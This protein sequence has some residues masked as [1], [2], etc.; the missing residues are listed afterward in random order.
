MSKK[1]ELTVKTIDV[2]GKLAEINFSDLVEALD[3]NGEL[4][5]DFKV[6]DNNTYK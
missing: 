1:K 4:V 2:N 3:L 5:T 6:R